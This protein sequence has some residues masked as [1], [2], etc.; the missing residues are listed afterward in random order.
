MI[1]CIDIYQFIDSNFIVQLEDVQQLFQKTFI[2]IKK[3]QLSMLPYD[4][5]I[6]KIKKKKLSNSSYV[7]NFYVS[8]YSV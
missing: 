4:A 5:F 1:K 2:V 3:V 6:L 8:H 7:L